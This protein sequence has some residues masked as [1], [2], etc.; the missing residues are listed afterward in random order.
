MSRGFSSLLLALAALLLL[1]AA[2]RIAPAQPSED[3]VAFKVAKG[4]VTYRIYCQNC[5]GASGIGDGRIAELLKVPTADLTLLSANNGGKFPV[6][7]AK[8]VLDGRSEVKGHGSREMPIW[9]EAFQTTLQPTFTELTDEERA[10]QKIEEVVLYL[11]TIQR[12]EE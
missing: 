10:V 1:L 5:H 9:G 6:E 7:E 12:I 8:R 4:R 3:E 2:P 11:K